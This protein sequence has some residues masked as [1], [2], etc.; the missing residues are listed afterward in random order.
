VDPPELLDVD[1]PEELLEP[2]LLDVLPDVDPVEPPELDPVELPE[3]V[4]PELVPELD[5]VEPLP[6]ELPCPSEEGVDEHA[7][8]HRAAAIIPRSGEGR[9]LETRCA[10]IARMNRI[11]LRRGHV[12]KFER[13]LAVSSAWRPVRQPP[14]PRVRRASSG[15]S[16]RFCHPSSRRCL[17]F[18][19]IV[20]PRRQLA[21]RR[22]L[23]DSGIR[24]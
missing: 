2:E 3:V 8:A 9:R 11:S 19:A 4:P 18:S 15:R 10:H 24:W 23:S 20:S 22:R 13:A 7:A 1:P 16:T 21:A 14:Y 12:L 17:F 6:A 5:P